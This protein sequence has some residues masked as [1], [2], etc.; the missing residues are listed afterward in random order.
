MKRQFPALLAQL[1][2]VL[3]P[4]SWDLKPAV[5]IA[6][7]LYMVHIL[8]QARTAMSES[9]AFLAFLFLAWAVGKGQLRASFHILYYP[10][11]L[12]GLTTVVSGL[13]SDTRHYGA[14]AIILVKALVFPTALILFREIP[15][16]RTSAVILHAAFATAI[17]M[18]G[19][20]QFFLLDQRDLEHRIRG[21]SSHVMTYSGLLLPLSLLF[22]F[23]RFHHRR[24]W[25]A[26]PAAVT[27]FA[28]LLTFTRSA[29]IGWAAALLLLLLAI[30]PRAVIAHAM[31]LLILAVVFMPMPMFTRLVSTFDARQSSNFDRIRMLQAG[32]EIIRDYPLLGVGPGNVK[33]V[34]PL[35]RLPDAPRFRVPHLHNNVVQIWAE[36]GFVAVL[37]YLLLL[38]LFLRECLRHWRGENRAWAQA[39]VAIVIGLTTA[40]LFEF[41]FG[42]TEVFYLML[43]LFALIVAMLEGEA[44][45]AARRMNGA[46]DVFPAATMSS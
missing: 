4:G 22:L 46:A 37:A 9:C 34:Y 2:A 31:P 28:L 33:E 19:I 21:L 30:R 15:R 27:T 18:V 40:G 16:L 24:W 23:L 17:G 29:W 43:D 11:A 3:R 39:G 32:V 6:A 13:A 36:R 42:D 14:G 25:L 35:Y 7:G 12:Y 1:A 5:F 10:L 44:P 26:L 38:G 41:N 8:F 45:G 20:G